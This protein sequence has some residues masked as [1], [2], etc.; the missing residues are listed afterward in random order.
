MPEKAPKRKRFLDYIKEKHFRGWKAEQDD[1][2]GAQ[3]SPFTDMQDIVKEHENIDLKIANDITEGPF[4]STL[5][6]PISDDL[7][8]S[9]VKKRNR[10]AS[11]V[12]RQD[13]YGASSSSC[14]WVCPI[15]GRFDADGGIPIYEDVKSHIMR[16]HGEYILDVKTRNGQCG[17][18]NLNFYDTHEL[19]KHLAYEHDM[20]MPK[21][22]AM[23]LDENDY[24]PQPFT[25]QKR[26]RY[27]CHSLIYRL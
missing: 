22:R 7:F 12:K 3:A 1:S 15:C 10:H 24:M 11:V 6:M 20:L 25:P 17:Q 23:G 21:I 18:C 27:I 19:L 9:V 13:E 14:R 4:Q 16:R 5:A 26:L 2:S 8:K